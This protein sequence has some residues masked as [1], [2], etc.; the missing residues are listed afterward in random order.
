MHTRKE[1]IPN[2]LKEIRMK[3]GLSQMAVAIQL[4]LSSGNQDRIYEIIFDKKEFAFIF[5]SLPHTAA[6]R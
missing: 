2:N 5:Y 1:I 4:G 3:A 6:N